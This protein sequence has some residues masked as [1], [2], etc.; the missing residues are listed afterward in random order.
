MVNFSKKYLGE[1]LRRD[2]WKDLAS[3]LGS[4][5]SYKR[6]RD[7]LCG[8]LSPSEQIVF[9][10]RVLIL[11]FLNRGWTYRQ[12]AEALDVSRSAISFFKNGFKRG[13]MGKKKY[14]N[15]T[16][17]DGFKSGKRDWI[18]MPP[19]TGKGRWRI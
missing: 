3:R 11:Y 4:E 9:E 8:F 17:S 13:T 10:K 6:L 19:I 15:R 2:S 7:L 12:I 1:N 5:L 18:L 14:Q 16:S